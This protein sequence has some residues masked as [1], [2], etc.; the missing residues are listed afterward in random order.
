ML[1]LLALASAA[2]IGPTVYEQKD[3]GDPIFAE[4]TYSLSADCTAATISV[5]VMNESQKPV[6]GANTYLKYVDFASPLI[7]SVK[8][9]DDGFAL[10]K[11]PGDVKLMRG[12][13]IL[14]IEHKGYRNKEI[15]FD[16]SGCYSNTTRPN[17]PAPPPP[18]TQPP[19]QNNTNGSTNPPP[20][21]NHTNNTNV[22][23]AT[24]N[25]MTGNETGT[26]ELP[27]MCAT[28]F[29]LASIF[30]FLKQS[31]RKDT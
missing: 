18:A 4:F 15:H 24:A 14:V 3:L 28:V 6:E 19:A 8:T 25:N 22:T 30:L 12:L 17:P 21:Q 26:T 23:N 16:I 11:L 7:S 27:G 9:D 5:I 10:H 2:V 20:A 1:L 13:F 31:S 29:A